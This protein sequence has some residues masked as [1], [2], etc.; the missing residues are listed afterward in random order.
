MSLILG[1]VLKAARSFITPSRL[2]SIAPYALIAVMLGFSY[3]KGGE[4][5][6]DV[7][8]IE[9]LEADKLSLTLELQANAALMRLATERA[10]E[11]EKLATKLQADIDTHLAEIAQ[12]ESNTE[13][14]AQNLN[15]TRQEYE[16][17]LAAA[18]AKPDAKPVAD[19]RNCTLDRRDRDWLLSIK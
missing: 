18:T 11:R 9:Q 3:W 16:Q 8:A 7:A 17:R 15:E 4:H 12:L 14:L 19:R 10:Q 1:I 6:R 13:A 2:W 5:A